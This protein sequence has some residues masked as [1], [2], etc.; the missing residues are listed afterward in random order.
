MPRNISTRKH[1]I[2]YWLMLSHA[3]VGDNQRYHQIQDS[4]LDIVLEP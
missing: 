1:V 4:E 2:K 3:W